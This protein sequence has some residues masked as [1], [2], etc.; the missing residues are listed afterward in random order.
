LQILLAKKA[1]FCAGVRKAFH[2]TEEARREGGRW[3]TLGPLV[4]NDEVVLYFKEKGIMPVNNI[5]DVDSGGVII[6]THGVSPKVIHEIEEKGCPIQDATCALVKRVHEVAELLGREGYDI[7]IFG[8][9]DHPEVKGILGWC[10]TKATVISNLH[11]ARE[12]IAIKKMGIISQ[13]TKD[14]KEFFSVISALLPK[15]QEIRIYNT[16]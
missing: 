12:F 11:E 14:E 3:Y 4:H 7:I 8:D 13:T 2:I 16:L 15:A 1:G 10:S 9:I 6:R 5:N